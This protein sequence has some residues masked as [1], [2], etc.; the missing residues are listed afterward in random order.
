MGPSPQHIL[1]REAMTVAGELRWLPALIY[2]R[3][4]LSMAYGNSEKSL[5]SG[6]DVRFYGN[7]EIIRY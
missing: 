1:T 4:N 3:V 2:N 6:S 5:A 7:C